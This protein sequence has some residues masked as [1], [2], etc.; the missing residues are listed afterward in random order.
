MITLKCLAFSALSLIAAPLSPVW[1]TDNDPGSIMSVGETFHNQTGFGSGGYRSKNISWGKEIPLYKE[2]A[3]AS[4]VK[5]PPPTFAGKSVEQAIRERRSYRHF[6]DQQMTLKE[7]SQLLLSANGVTS[8]SGP[9]HRAAPSAGALYPIE[10][11]VAAANIE[12]LENGIYH[13][14]VSD[15]SLELVKAGNFNDSLHLAANEQ[16]SIGSSP[17]TMILTGRFDR[18]T[19]KYA[20]RGFRYSYIESGAI[21]ENIYL[22]AISFDMGTCAVGAFNDDALNALLGIDGIKEAALL[23]MPVGHL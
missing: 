18:S 9:A 6:T 11:Y 5:L 15:S 4:K 10:I 22:Q 14:Q 1:S 13:F 19:K 12:S 3:G 20:D 23:L 8:V 2:Y 21:C 17:C 7:L 16:G